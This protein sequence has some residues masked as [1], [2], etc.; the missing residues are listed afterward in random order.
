MSGALADVARPAP[1]TP[2]VVP[3][4]PSDPNM[5]PLD[6]L[7]GMA[8]VQA[9]FRAR[10]LRDP[11][12]AVEH[13]SFPAALRNRLPVAVSLTELASVALRGYQRTRGA[14]AEPP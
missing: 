11:R 6:L 1:G 8:A 13:P 4:V 7:I 2:P 12:G 9:S 10:L 3:I 5:D 14:W